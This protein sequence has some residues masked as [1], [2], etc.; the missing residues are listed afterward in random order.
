MLH[1][2]TVSPAMW[3]LMQRLM[4]DEVLKDFVLVGG[5]ALSLK[6]G[7]RLSVDIDLFRQDGFDAKELHIYLEDNYNAQSAHVFKN[8]V[9]TF[10]DDI[11]VDLISHQYPYLKPFETV[12][13]VR[14]VSLEDIGAM[15]LLAIAQS[16]RRIKDFVDMYQLLEYNPLVVYLEGYARKYGANPIGAR[17]AINDFNNVSSKQIMEYFPGKK[18][19]WEKIIERLWH[20]KINI[21][22]LFEPVRKEDYGIKPGNNKRRGFKI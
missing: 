20:A 4:K 1:K 16:G 13:D 17:N 15:K 19:E 5:T 14:L 7:H 2:N 10:I 9:M 22:T 18:E 12:E 21:R 6:I 3:E 11:K 8:S